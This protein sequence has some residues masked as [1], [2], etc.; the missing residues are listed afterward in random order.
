MVSGE[1]EARDTRCWCAGHPQEPENCPVLREFRQLATPEGRELARAEY[2]AEA[3]ERASS[4]KW[5]SRGRA[6]YRLQQL[7]VPAV[8]ITA[9]RDAS[10][11]TGSLL[12]ARRFVDDGERWF[13]ALIGASGIGKSLAATYVLQ[14]FVRRYPWNAQATGISQEPAV[15]LSAADLTGA[16][17]WE[18]NHRS[19][20]RAAEGAKLLVVDDMGDE[21]TPVGIAALV[22]L[23]MARADDKRRTVLTSNLTR[24]GFVRRYGA[25]LADRLKVCAVTPNLADEKSL[26][27]RAP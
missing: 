4:S 8:A 13:L 7:G 5:E 21:G 18:E 2:R 24:D 19:R 15:Y 20:M 27:R 23:L 12:A 26:R 10:V 11:A 17:A 22:R 16:T 3:Q 14:E 9:L 6:A 25:A 1:T